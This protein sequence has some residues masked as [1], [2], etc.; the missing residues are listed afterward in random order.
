MARMKKNILT[1]MTGQEKKYMRKIE[2]V[3]R[4]EGVTKLEMPEQKREALELF[5]IK[6]QKKCARVIHELI[7]QLVDD[8]KGN[9][10]HSK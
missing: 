2:I 5:R 9:G 8:E 10:V 1:S 7:D 6:R 3:L 4:N